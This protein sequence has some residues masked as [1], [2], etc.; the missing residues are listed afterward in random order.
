MRITTIIDVGYIYVI[1]QGF[2]FS[3]LPFLV[4]TAATG[5]ILST[6]RCSI[7]VPFDEKSP[8]LYGACTGCA[9]RVGVDVRAGDVEVDMSYTGIR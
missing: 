3:I 6:I 2:Q 4:F 9:I 1:T 5:S 8:E 7:M